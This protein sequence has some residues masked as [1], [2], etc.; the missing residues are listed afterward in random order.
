MA[1]PWL[2]GLFPS[3]DPGRFWVPESETLQVVP[4]A[5]VV[6]VGSSHR[7]VCISCDLREV[8][9]N[10]IDVAPAW[11]PRVRCSRKVF[12]CTGMLDGRIF[13]HSVIS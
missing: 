8:M 6:A 11:I 2:T 1:T 7:L 13:A 5:P 9:Y 4:C 10:A 3:H 12:S